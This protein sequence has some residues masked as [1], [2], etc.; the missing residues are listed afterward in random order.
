M[1]ARLCSLPSS[2]YGV[3]MGYKESPVSEA[4]LRFSGLLGDLFAVYLSG[5]C[6]CLA[7]A[8]GGDVDLVLPVPSTSRPGPA[9]LERVRRLPA[10]VAEAWGDGAHWVPS[11][12][13]RGDGPVGHMHPNDRAFALGDELDVEIAGARVL[14]LDDTYVSGARSQ[15]AAAALRRSGA[16]SVAIVP[17]GR[18]LRPDR[19]EAHA[20]FLKQARRQRDD[21]HCARCLAPAV[22]AYALPM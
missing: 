12:L 13:R 5:H 3:L 2:L 17:L 16:A 14:L 8:L 18:V 15:S 6:R 4:R 19:S 1:P 9:P 11:L 21:G 22:S 20:V 10:V 7:A